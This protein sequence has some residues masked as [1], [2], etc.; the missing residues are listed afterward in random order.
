LKA[1]SEEKGLLCQVSAGL[2][3]LGM[4]FGIFIQT[5]TQIQYI[6]KFHNETLYSYLKQT[7]M[8]FFKNREQEGKTGPVWGLVPVTKGRI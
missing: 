3:S 7:K 8:L 2:E 1:T 5:E 4:N 6:W